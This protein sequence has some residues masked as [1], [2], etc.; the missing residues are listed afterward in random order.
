MVLKVCKKDNELAKQ[1]RMMNR[2]KI[3]RKSLKD[4]HQHNATDGKTNFSP[5]KP[6]KNRS[7]MQQ[8]ERLISVSKE[9]SK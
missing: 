8:M 7:Q 9:T 6:A 1:A 2:S 5:K 3:D 4:P